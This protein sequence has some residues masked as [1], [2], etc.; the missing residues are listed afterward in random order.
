MLSIT[1]A[2]LGRMRR[3]LLFD[4]PERGRKLSRFWTLLILAA[5]RPVEQEVVPHPREV[6]L[7]DREHPRTLPPAAD[8]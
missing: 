8:G 5:L 3:D 6:G 2:D 1:E 4:G 7:G